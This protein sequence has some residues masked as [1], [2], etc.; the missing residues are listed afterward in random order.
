MTA[1]WW[2]V[3]AGLVLVVGCK[4][5][6][7]DTG[8]AG[9]D[10]PDHPHDDNGC[11]WDGVR[12]PGTHRLF[13]QGS[14]AD[15]DGR[16]IYPF[17]H[18][19]GNEGEDAALCDDATFVDDGNGDGVW[20]PGEAPRELAPG[21][22]VHGEHYL[23]GVGAFVE[24]GITLCDDITGNVA[25]YVPNFDEAGSQALHQLFV[26]HEDE[27]TLVAEVVDDEAGMSGYN[28]FVRVVEGED[29]DAVAGDMLLM[30]TTNL[31]GIP[32]SVM[33]FLP[34]SEYE[35]WVLVEVP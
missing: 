2:L 13:A 7:V 5:S 14:E 10:R 17:L 15:P 29:P 16:G 1:V 12:G 32:F 3:A 4:S 6:D 19:W 27:E 34:P 11:P 22:L 21:G 33:V 24:F 8:G 31:N 28:P 26:V 18:E 9:D 30:R 25:F 20:Q 35:S 23:V